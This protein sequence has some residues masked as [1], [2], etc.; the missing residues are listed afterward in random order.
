M[1][2]VTNPPIAIST[3]AATVIHPPHDTCGIKMRI[4]TRNAR[5]E[6]ISVGI[7]RMKRPSRKRG[8][9]PGLW[10]C[11]A[12]ARI[13]HIKARNAATGWMIRIE[14]SE[15]RVPSGSEKS[16]LVMPL[17]LFIS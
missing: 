13:V 10:K 8:E 7:V 2:H 11:A 4:S 9:C 3:V 1:P 12:M 15:L 6:H 16:S 14:E 17:M 5:S